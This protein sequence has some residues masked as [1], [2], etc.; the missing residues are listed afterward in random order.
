MRDLPQEKTF[1]HGNII[2]L[3]IP[4]LLLKQGNNNKKEIAGSYKVL[5]NIME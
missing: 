4:Q 2:S 5:C 3:I 1:E